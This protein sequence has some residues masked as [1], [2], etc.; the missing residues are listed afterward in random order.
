VVPFIREVAC[1]GPASHPVYR[2]QDKHW[3]LPK[4]PSR[5]LTTMS[6]KQ[7]DRE[8]IISERMGTKQKHIFEGR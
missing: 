3:V 5:L 8:P 1:D 7:E 4:K 2:N 6:R